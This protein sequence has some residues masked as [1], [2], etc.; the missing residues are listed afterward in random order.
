L[1]YESR[2][3]ED[4]PGRARLRQQSILRA[5]RRNGERPAYDAQDKEEDPAT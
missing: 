2:D 1:E 4:Q 5:D 3:Q